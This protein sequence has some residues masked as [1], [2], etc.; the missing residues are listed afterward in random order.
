[1]YINNKEYAA[2]GFI[3][4]EVGILYYSHDYSCVPNV[5][6]CTIFSNWTDGSLDEFTERELACTRW[7]PCIT[8]PIIA[9]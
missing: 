2:S 3:K 4:H 1:M 6:N 9:R 8:E 7:K 5:I